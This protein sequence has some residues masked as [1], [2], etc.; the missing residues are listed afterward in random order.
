MWTSDRHGKS[1]LS[2][3]MTF[4]NSAPRLIRDVDDGSARR[5]CKLLKVSGRVQEVG[6]VLVLECESIAAPPLQL[7][8]NI[9]S[10]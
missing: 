2:E 3:S 6:P 4:L 1:S 5:K 8:T 7:T 9:F 10:L